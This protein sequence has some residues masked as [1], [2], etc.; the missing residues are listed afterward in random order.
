MTDLPLACALTGADFRA[1]RDLVLES[2]FNQRDGTEELADG[3]AFRFDNA[4]RWAAPALEF[5][6]IEQTCCPFFTFQLEFSPA[7]GPLR[8]K[9]LGPDGVKEFI[10]NELGL[11]ES[12]ERHVTH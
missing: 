11:V 3:Y 6:E 2:F 9:L 5:I 4:R 1:R 8:L 7:S 12:G 10:R